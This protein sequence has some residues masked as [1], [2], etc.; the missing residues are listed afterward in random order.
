[1]LITQ[2]VKVKM[3]VLPFSEKCTFLKRNFF[4]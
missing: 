1:M 3:S 4:Q 2:C